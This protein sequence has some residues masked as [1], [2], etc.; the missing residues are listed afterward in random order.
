LRGSPDGLVHSQDSGSSERGAIYVPNATFKAQILMKSAK[1]VQKRTKLTESHVTGII[2]WLAFSMRSVFRLTDATDS[3][4][5]AGRDLAL[6]ARSSH[7]L[8]AGVPS[9]F[10][11][12]G[13]WT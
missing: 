6:P 8:V 7:Q 1:S 2:A 10:W 5:L 3:R 11:G 4:I 13:T 12:E 9:P